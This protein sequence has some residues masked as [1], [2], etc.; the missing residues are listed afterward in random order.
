MSNKTKTKLA[1][2]LIELLV[3][4]AI[5]GILSAL[6]IVGMSSATQKATIAKAQVFS[7][8]LRN[9]LMGNL[10]SEWKFDVINSPAAN[11]TPDTWGT[12]TGT[13]GNGSTATTFPTLVTTESSCVSGKCF[14]FDGGDYV[15]CGSGTTLNMGT[16]DFS[17]GFWVKVP[18]ISVNAWLI[19]KE[20]SDTTQRFNFYIR[21]SVGYIQFALTDDAGHALYLFSGVTTRIDNNV[22]H[23]AFV[24]ITRGSST[25]GKLYV[26]GVLIALADVTS[27]TGSISNTNILTIGARYTTGASD[28]LAGS[29]DDVRIFDAAMPTSQIQQLYF[30]GLNKLFAKNQISGEE[31]QHRLAELSNNYSKN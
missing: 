2:T 4:I 13:L 1:F 29:I 24:T 22:W 19:G 7:N 27:L 28:F 5:I 15:D 26:D 6:I 3:V 21:P 25:G 16:G 23:N 12:N 14:S 20:K 8:S 11:Q 18:T 10:V 9:S 30:V 31:Y 17:T